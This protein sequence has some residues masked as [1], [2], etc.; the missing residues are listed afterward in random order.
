MT[1]IRL[2]Q[3]FADCVD[4]CGKNISERTYWIHN[5]VGGVGWQV[6]RKKVSYGTEWSGT[7]WV[8]KVDD[9]GDAIVYRLVCGK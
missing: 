3:N 4:W 7:E 6:F 2:G 1:E 5:K 8:L 9:E